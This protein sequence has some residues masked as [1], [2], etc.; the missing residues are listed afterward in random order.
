M[1]VS[2]NCMT[3][4]PADRVAAMLGLFR[5]IA[6]EIVVVVDDRA[7]PETEAAL[8]SV[9]SRLL[10]YPYEEPVDRPLAWIH[11]QCTGDWVLTID[12][13]E[14]PSR[15]LLDAVQE[16]ATARDVTH[17]WL[18]RRWLYPTPDKQWDI[19]RQAYQNKRWDVAVKEFK[20]FE[21]GTPVGE[22][23]D[24]S[25]WGRLP[26][27]L[28]RNRDGRHFD[29][30]AAVSGLES[31]ANQRGL[32]VLDADGD[33]T[34]DLF[35]AGFLQ[36]PQLWINRNPS[37]AKTLVVS[38]RGDPS[39][40]GP[41]RSTREALGAAVTVTANGLSR[42]QFVSAGYSFLSSGSRELYFG[43]GD[44][45]AAERVVVRWPSGGVTERRDVA[46]GRLELDEIDR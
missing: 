13:D 20:K 18:P 21:K 5:G 1:S 39:A 43:L 8:A 10:R 23:G 7:G 3:R 40:K 14:V 37:H 25:L 19:A 16:L 30:I 24:D 46:A 44:A 29:E 6:D 27:R 42:T 28:Y 15:A 36:P 2:V 22:W 38:L 35:A 9:A 31:T 17:Y 45:P 32:V 33:G 12:D 11:A 26:K 34:P 4:G 41:H